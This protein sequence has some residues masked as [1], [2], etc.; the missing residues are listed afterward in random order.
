MDLDGYRNYLGIPVIGA[1]KWLSD[2]GFGVGT[3]MTVQEAYAPLRYL[4]TAFLCVITVAAFFALTTAFSSFS[5]L[6]LRRQV[7]EARQLGQYTLL[8]LIGQGGMGKVFRA[9]HAML[10]RP[11]AVKLLDGVDAD[12]ESVQRF[13]R[14]VELT[15][16]LTH[17]NTIQIYDYG[18]TPDGV[19]YYAMEYLPGVTLAQLVA[20]DGAVPPARVIHVLRQACASLNEAHDRGLVHRDVKPANIMLCERGG[21]Y[22]VVKVLDFGMATSVEPQDGRRITKN[23]QIGGTPLYWAGK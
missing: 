11:T 5:I 21:L 20:L 1:W 8:E 15:T 12:R 3:E 23:W 4:K 10:Q 14:E 17:P 22:D 7:S 6:Q 13:Q 9:K 19:F 18:L 16:R 2:D